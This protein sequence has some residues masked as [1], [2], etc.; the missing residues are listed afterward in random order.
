[1][2]KSEFPQG[3][4]L[5]PLLFNTFLHDMHDNGPIHNSIYLFFTDDT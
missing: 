5:G 1:M 3:Y 4:A 2:M